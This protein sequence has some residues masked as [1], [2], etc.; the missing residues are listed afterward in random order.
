MWILLIISWL[1]YFFWYLWLFL[2]PRTD[3]F[4]VW[5][6]IVIR[7]IKVRNRFTNFYLI[8]TLSMLTISNPVKFRYFSIPYSIYSMP[9]I[10]HR[11]H[12]TCRAANKYVILTWHTF[13]HL[14]SFDHR[15]ITLAL[16][17]PWDNSTDLNQTRIRP[18]M[19][20]QVIL[21]AVEIRY[22]SALYSSIYRLRYI[23][24]YKPNKAQ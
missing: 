5:I 7:W 15:Q 10:S 6:E 17:T 18:I 13:E 12:S 1:F 3:Y 4:R 21:D 16:T 24:E 11:P 8:F 19:T 20:T 22:W 23:E 2:Q 14:L 9:S